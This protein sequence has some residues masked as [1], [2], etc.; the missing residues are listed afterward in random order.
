[1]RGSAVG[2]SKRDAVAFT[3]FAMLGNR[4]ATRRSEFVVTTGMRSQLRRLLNA[5]PRARMALEWPAGGIPTARIG[6][7]GLSTP[8]TR[9]RRPLVR[10]EL[11][12]TAATGLPLASLMLAVAVCAD[13]ALLNPVGP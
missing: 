6:F 10:T 1:M 13:A 4:G 7:A 9:C 5:V 8:L 2:S 12:L 3:A 11:L